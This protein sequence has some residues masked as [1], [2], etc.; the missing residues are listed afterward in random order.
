MQSCM[1]HEAQVTDARP[2]SADQLADIGIARRAGEDEFRVL[3]SGRLPGREQM[4]HALAHRH[5]PSEEG[6]ESLS[7]R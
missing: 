7:R 6:A 4:M 1:R 3:Q 2:G 5:L